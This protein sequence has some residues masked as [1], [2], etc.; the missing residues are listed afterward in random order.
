VKNLEEDA[1]C[2]MAQ[3]FFQLD[4]KNSKSL[5]TLV[6]TKTHGNIFFTLEF[7]QA[8]I[9]AD[10]FESDGEGQFDVEE[11]RIEFGSVNDL[12][13]TKI[14][15]LPEETQEVLKFASFLGS[16]LDVEILQRLTMEPISSCLQTAEER[17]L[18]VYQSL[19]RHWQFAHDGIQEL[20]WGQIPANER[21][22]FRYRLGRKL[23]RSF[24]MDELDRF[25]FVVVGQFMVASDLMT[26]E[27]ERVAVAKL[28]LRAGERAVQLSS[29]QTSFIYLKQGISLLGLRSWRDEYSLC[30]NL[31]NSAAEVACCTGQFDT[32]YELVDE[33][34]RNSRSVDD[35]LP[36]LTTKIHALGSSGRLREAVHLGLELLK[37]LGE[38]F[39]SKAAPVHA[40]RE[41]QRIEKRLKGKTDE[42]ILR[43]PLMKDSN[44]LSAM[45]ILNVIFL[46]VFMTDKHLAPLVG[47]RVMT[48]TLDHGLCTVSCL[49]FAIVAMYLC[50]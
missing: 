47:F 4:R 5:A 49:G 19:S 2:A 15:E 3:D 40:K 29:F 12:I 35:T 45:Q 42:D 7:F 48:L 41:F 11:V 6:F 13:I 38:A 16:N 17:G 20:I 8:I 33:V 1:V 9:D 18:I 28:Y 32:V 30:L 39:P 23:W 22:A 34:A 24:D 31:Y 10:I 26:E 50:G 21:R 37:H 14:R 25:I 36:S 44:S 46:Y 27:K 43:L